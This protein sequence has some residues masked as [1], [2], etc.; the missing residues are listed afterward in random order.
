MIM[1][2]YDDKVV[3]VMVKKWGQA[4]SDGCDGGIMMVEWCQL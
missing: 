4:R 2:C 3:V 1:I